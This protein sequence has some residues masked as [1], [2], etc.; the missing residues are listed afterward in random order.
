MKSMMLAGAVA[1]VL[2]AAGAAAAKDARCYTTDDGEYDC[3]FEM[4]DD[5]GSFEI[6]A[7]KKP[8]FQLWMDAPGVAFASAV[9]EPGGRSVALPGTYHRSEE[10]GACWVSDATDTEICAW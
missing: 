5:A 2:G 10:D 1:L 4:L 9:F 7:K 8:T 6:S 3:R